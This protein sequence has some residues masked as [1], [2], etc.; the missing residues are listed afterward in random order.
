MGEWRKP[1][2]FKFSEAESAML[3]R[4][5]ESLAPMHENESQTVRW[6]VRIVHFLIFTKGMLPKLA[7]MIQGLQGSEVYDIPTHA[8]PEKPRIRAARTER[9]VAQ[10]VNAPLRFSTTRARATWGTSLSL[11]NLR[12]AWSGVQA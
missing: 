6:S 11:P 5:H 8:A 2:T 3:L 10:G 4:I 9:R 7:A 1:R 12:P